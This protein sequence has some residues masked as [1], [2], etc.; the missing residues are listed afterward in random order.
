MGV[1]IDRQ[2]GIRVCRA[3]RRR[4][5]K[6]LED[7]LFLT[8]VVFA[9]WWQTPVAALICFCARASQKQLRFASSYQY[10]DT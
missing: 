2:V 3:A 1:A 9:W 5:E 4:N 6:R 7:G 8:Y 10:E